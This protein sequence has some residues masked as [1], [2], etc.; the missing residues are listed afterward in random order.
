MQ[1]GVL[2]ELL[3]GLLLL[4]AERHA[5]E[6]LG[7]TVVHDQNVKLVEYHVLFV[8][9]EIPQGDIDFV[10]LVDESLLGGSEDELQL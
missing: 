3:E 2:S 10:T 5:V 9:V 1:F 7:R 6:E 4:P 8:L